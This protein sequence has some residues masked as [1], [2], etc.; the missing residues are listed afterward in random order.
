MSFKPGLRLRYFI[1]ELFVCQILFAQ[2]STTTVPEHGAKPVRSSAPREVIHWLRTAAIP[3]RTTVPDA[4][5]DDMSPVR[6]VVGNARIVAM[7]EA[8]HGTREF[9]RMKHRMLRFLVE[10]M[11]FTAF[12]IEANWPES[13]AVNDY[14]LNGKGDPAQA[15]A[16]LYFWTWNTEE[17]LDMIRWMRQY[18]EN[19]AHVRRV[20]FFGFDM[21]I[22]R[23]AVSN[24]QQY[25]ERVDPQG[26]Q[27]ATKVLSPL[28]DE[29][30]E[31]KY[32]SQRQQLREETAKGL[33]SLLVL[34]DQHERD[35][36]AS[37]SEREWAVARHN[38]EIVR[39]A[40][41]LY[42]SRS[43]SLRDVSFSIRDN[44][45][46]E[47]VKWTLDHEPTETKIM[48]WAHN[49][50]VS[51]SPSAMG[52][53]LRKM[54]GHDMVVCGFSFYQ[55]SFQAVS[56][57][58]Q[59][60]QDFTV[61]TAPPDTLDSALADTGFPFLAIDLRD[62]PSHGAVGEWFATPRRTRSIGAVYNPFFPVSTSY[63]VPIARDTF[64]VIFFVNQ[65]TPARKNP[66]LPKQREPDFIRG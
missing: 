13:L 24:V 56:G 51:T 26:Y 60:L 15:L 45:M 57:L 32:P 2:V 10:E 52:S 53:V 37:S 50:H 5:S 38:L 46:A 34:F 27:L 14:V 21:Q 7:G 39:Q 65:T 59:R 49:G 40:E 9:F 62:A 44:F 41:E 55:G 6:A 23:V 17:V 47:N 20:Q 66:P 31:Q 35:Y 42:S 29:P 4:D 36:A 11:G 12:A 19:P 3:L 1:L 61:G 25:L 18:Y 16:G 63:F 8:T 22:A 58:N 30:S 28:A 64:D 33:K 54:Y 43:S 48:L